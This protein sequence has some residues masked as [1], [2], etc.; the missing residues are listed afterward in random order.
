MGQIPADYLPPKGLWP[1]RIYTLPEHQTYPQ[2]F[3][4]T[5]EL[6]DKP[7]AAGKGD[8]VAIY[9]EDKKLPYKAVWATV[10]KL[11]SAL[12]RL[13]VAEADRVML[14]LP[15]IPPAVLANFAIIKIGAVSLP[16]SALFS[17]AEITHV[18]NLAEA[19][20]VVVAG[21]LL[22]ELEKAKP[23]CKTL[24][25]VIVVGGTPEQQAA[26]KGK[27]YCLWQE[28]LDAEKPECE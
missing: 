8:R 9:F 26:W 18:A 28:L 13:G 3:N 15:N 10:N 25:H 6:L 23:N 20:A 5:E 21:A 2:R 14:R 11:G 17:Q 24:Q 19:K 22:E 27:G 16:T 1:D 12:K 4:S 7:V